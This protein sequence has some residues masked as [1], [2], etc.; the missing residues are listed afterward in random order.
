MPRLPALLLHRP[1]RVA[2]SVA[3]L[4]GFC[5]CLRARHSAVA[6]LRKCLWSA[7]CYGPAELGF[8][9]PGRPEV[10]QIRRTL[11]A[12]RAIRPAG[13]WPFQ[14]Q[15]QVDQLPGCRLGCALVVLHCC[16]RAV[17]AIFLTLC[18]RQQA[19]DSLGGAGDQVATAALQPE[20]PQ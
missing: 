10:A 19:T 17:V 18:R 11:H 9:P 12:W 6:T 4:V 13:V 20:Q 1:D 16:S 15:S 14:P 5:N 8:R 7:G 3:S 2:W